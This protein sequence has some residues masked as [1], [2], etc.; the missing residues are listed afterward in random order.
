MKLWRLA[1]KAI[2]WFWRRA[3]AA[4]EYADEVEG[5]AVNLDKINPKL[6]LHAKVVRHVGNIN[7]AFQYVEEKYGT[8][9]EFFKAL[10]EAFD[11]GAQT[12]TLNRTQIEYV[13]QLKKNPIQLVKEL[14]DMFG[15]KRT[16]VQPAPLPMPAG[17]DDDDEDAEPDD[18][19][20]VP[21]PPA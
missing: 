1:A 2:K 7:S 10:E 19:A 20:S 4:M 16:P 11:S 14:G 13:Y 21:G 18:G 8:H 5:I 17:I 15:K 9:A 3:Q 12:L 6:K